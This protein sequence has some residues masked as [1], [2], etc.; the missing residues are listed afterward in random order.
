MICKWHPFFP[1][2][3]I[4]SVH[5]FRRSGLIMIC[6]LHPFRLS[7]PDRLW[8]ICLQRW[9]H[10]STE[11]IDRDLFAGSHCLSEPKELIIRVWTGLSCPTRKYMTQHAHSRRAWNDPWQSA[12]PR[13]VLQG[14]SSQ[15]R[16]ARADA[17]VQDSRDAHERD[18]SRGAPCSRRGYRNGH[19]RTL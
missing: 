12:R 15:A 6:K 11:P 18:A 4:R 3:L 16:R 8:S 9:M 1:S 7:I 10:C 13:P 19:G 17:T 5:I 2:I 14:R